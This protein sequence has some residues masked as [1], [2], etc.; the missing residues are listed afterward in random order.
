MSVKI[1]RQSIL[2]SI[3]IYFG[4]AVGFLNTYFFTRNDFFTTEQYGLVS[5]VTSSV[6]PLIAS[7]ASMAMPSFIYKFY[8]YYNDNLEQGKN[9]MF[10]LVL[11][12]SL[13]G[14]LILTAAGFLFEGLVVKKYSAKSPLF[15]QYY[16]WVFIM[17][18]GLTLYNILEAYAWSLHKSVLTNYLKEVQWRLFTSVIIV[19]F[20]LKIIPD[21]DTFIRFYFF[22]FLSIAIT[23]FIYLLVTK[24]L[25]LTFSISRVTKKFFKKISKFC[26]FVYTA[27]LVF[28]F[29][30]AFD[31]IVIAAAIPNGA[32]KAAVFGL[33]QIMTSVIQAP[34]RGVVAAAIPHLSQAWKDKNYPTIQRIYQRS[35]INM[36]IF[37]SGLFILIALNYTDAIKTLGI[38]QEYILGF[39]AFL[40]LGL[41]KVVD[42][43]TGVNAQI[44]GTSNFWRFELICGLILL[45]ITMPL[46]YYLALKM[47]IL[48]PAI[49]QFISVS[50]YNIIRISFLYKKFRY[51]PFT[52]QTV[53][54][55]LLATLT[56]FMIYFLFRN[57]TGWMPLM[58][59]T[60][61][62]LLIFGGSVYFFKLSPDI[63]P[64]LQSITNRRLL[65]NKKE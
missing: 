55:I 37:A 35:S 1:R 65:K 63:E 59:R 50:I 21:F 13:I 53:Y 54:T 22:S 52:K 14:F 18:F 6:V 49:A 25:F 41:T 47:D 61:S 38:N 19:L 20:L 46:T 64:V 29:S 39:Q 16:H 24:R 36:L 7:F 2:S 56:F 5:L 57:E 31:I 58:I 45:I 28:T 23:L 27:N 4:F 26:F 15:V 43:G 48:G 60:I 11:V 42:L 12:V 32:S 62:V 17:G 44:I 33:A 30:G 51:M 9:D 40:F 10:S 34:Q 3:V 8:P